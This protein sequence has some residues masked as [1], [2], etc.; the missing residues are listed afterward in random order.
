MEITTDLILTMVTVFTIGMGVGAYFKEKKL[1][2]T[3]NP[4]VK[5]YMSQK[6]DMWKEF[7]KR[8]KV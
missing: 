2:K 4:W 3:F 6:A 8:I 1:E 5:K 7:K